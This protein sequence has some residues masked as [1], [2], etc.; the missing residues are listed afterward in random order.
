MRVPILMYHS[1]S[2]RPA[3][4]FEGLA[5]SP[6]RFAEQLRFLAAEG[7][8]PITVGRLVRSRSAG[9][10]PDRPVVLTFDDGFA[11]FHHTA[12]PLL[13][14]NEASATLYVVADLVAGTPGRASPE[15][16]WRMPIVDWSQL[17]DVAANGIEIGGHS[18]THPALD[19]L[20]LD[21]ARCEIELCKTRLQD[22]LGIEVSSFAYPYGFYSRQVR[23]L[24]VEAGYESACAVRYDLSSPTDD[25]FALC[26]QIVRPATDL[27]AFAAILRGEAPHRFVDRVRSRGWTFVRH[28]IRGTL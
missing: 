17:A 11:D 28:A 20:P 6:A 8:T 2:D 27:A 19:M 26:R 12:L 24:V 7:Y 15:S 5:V 3:P 23:R 21:E 18:L 16:P 13:V 25:P 4:G 10:L 9:T 14:R 22:H 1:I